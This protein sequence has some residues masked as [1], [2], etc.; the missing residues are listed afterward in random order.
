MGPDLPLLLRNQDAEPMAQPE[1]IVLRKRSATEAELA[2]Y[3][4]TCMQLR[5]SA[6]AAE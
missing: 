5:P 4:N 3:N 1:S 2:S 6:E